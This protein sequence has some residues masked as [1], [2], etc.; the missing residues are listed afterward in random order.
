[1]ATKSAAE[2]NTDATDVAAPASVE[3]PVDIVKARADARAKASKKLAG[4]LEAL[5]HG[6]AVWALL[7]A[8]AVPAHSRTTDPLE[9]VAIFREDFPASYFAAAEAKDKKKA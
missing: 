4:E 3:P 1:M 7:S 5:D 9:A 8:L 2:K 6:S